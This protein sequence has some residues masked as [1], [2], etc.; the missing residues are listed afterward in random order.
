VTDATPGAPFADGPPR[1]VHPLD[2]DAL[3]TRSGI[4][5]AGLRRL[6]DLGIVRERDDGRF[7]DDDVTAV[8]LALAL[9][10]SG[11]PLDDVASALRR[12]EFPPLD[13]VLLLEP[14]G[15]LPQTYGEIAGELGL[16]VDGVAR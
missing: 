10:S 14:I 16:D 15:L 5:E 8:R 4:D 11:I 12:G 9:E 6:V 1:D 13:S 7:G 2:A 3:A